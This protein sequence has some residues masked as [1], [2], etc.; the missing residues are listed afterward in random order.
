MERVLALAAKCNAVLPSYVVAIIIWHRV[1][2]CK[3]GE[4]YV[5][6]R[7]ELGA[8]AYQQLGHLSRPVLGRP[9]KRGD[10]ILARHM[11]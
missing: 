10:P 2:I 8:V 7:V 5:I 9:V 3:H 4:D 1:S 11:N 6:L